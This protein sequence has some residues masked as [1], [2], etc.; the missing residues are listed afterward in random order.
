LLL[1]VVLLTKSVIVIKINSRRQQR[2]IYQGG[3]LVARPVVIWDL[4]DDPE[5]NYIHICVEHEITQDEVDDILCNEDN[6]TVESRSSGRPTTFGWTETGRYI[7]VVWE[8]IDDDPYT[9]RPVTAYE[10]PPSAGD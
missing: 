10:V 1:G 5:G 7:A 9:V 6:E 2:P 4:E 3:T 8:H